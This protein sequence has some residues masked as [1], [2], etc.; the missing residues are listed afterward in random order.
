VWY[1]VIL[2]GFELLAILCL[3]RVKLCAA[4]LDMILV[5]NVIIDIVVMIEPS[6]DI[7]LYVDI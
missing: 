3:S 6:D 4:V 2:G 7:K 5:V 1:L